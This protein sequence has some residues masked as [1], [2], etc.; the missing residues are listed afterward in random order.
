MTRAQ[1]EA[2]AREVGY[3]PTEDDTDDELRMLIH[4]RQ[5]AL[6]V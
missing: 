1:L 4:E 5:P 6:A 3:E 2:L